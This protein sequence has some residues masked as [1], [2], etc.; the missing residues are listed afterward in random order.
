MRSF[1]EKKVF[2][3]CNVSAFAVFF[4]DFCQQEFTGIKFKVNFFKKRIKIKF[5]D[6]KLSI[7]F[8]FC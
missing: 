4:N 2:A 5:I 1:T 7:F 8:S 6:R 3:L